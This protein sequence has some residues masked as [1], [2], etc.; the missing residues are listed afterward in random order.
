MAYK[1]VKRVS[2][3]PELSEYLQLDAESECLRLV[4]EED[5]A[6]DSITPA[7]KRELMRVQT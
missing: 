7:L 4:V 5:E 2:R 1:I 3:H 6:M